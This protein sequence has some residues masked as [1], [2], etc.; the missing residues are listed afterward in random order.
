MR[1]RTE[2]TLNLQK[3][4]FSMMRLITKSLFDVS[5]ACDVE[6]NTR[7]PR[8]LDWLAAVGWAAC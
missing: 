1:M 3:A 6:R 5:P 7:D 2:A 4:S 8:G